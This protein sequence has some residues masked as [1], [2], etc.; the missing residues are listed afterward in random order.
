MG[1]LRRFLRAFWHDRSGLSA[2]EYALLAAFVTVG[3]ATAG[4]QLSGAV[5]G[6]ME[7]VAGCLDGT[8]LPTSC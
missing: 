3:I 2:V 1:T 5:F 4:V 7:R 6:T 8:V